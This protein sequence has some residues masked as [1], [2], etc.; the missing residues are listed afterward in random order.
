MTQRTRSTSPTSAPSRRI[1]VV[2]A[3]MAGIAC[4]RT[5][6]QAGHQVRVFE[7]LAAPGG[8]MAS[9]ASPFGS[10]DHGAQYFTVRDA[11]FQQ[12]LTATAPQLCRPWSANTVRVL[13]PFGRVAAAALPPAEAHWVPVPGMDAL[14]RRWAAPLVAAQA[15]EYETQAV[16]ITADTIHPAKW[17]IATVGTAGEPD[18]QHVFGGFDA[19]VLAVPHAQA[20]QLLRASNLAPAVQKRL[21]SVRVGPCWALLL[22]F[23]Q[24]VQ[25]TLAHLGPQWNAARST[26]H[27]IA[28]LARESSKPGRGAVE[29][30]TVQASTAWSAEHQQD[31]AARVQAKLRRAFSEVTGILAE[32]AFAR[33]HG[34]HQAQT[35]AP[36]GQ[37]HVWDARLRIGLAGDWCLGHRVDDA[38]VSGVELALAMACAPRRAAPSKLAPQCVARRLVSPPRPAVSPPLPPVRCTPARWS[39][40]S[41]AG[42]THGPVADAGWCASRTST[43]RAVPLAPTR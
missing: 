36:L 10:F 43:R 28:W 42:S 9:L 25:P 11:R 31:D 39:R 40:R 30:W 34:W 26:H 12:A 21:E 6:V 13:D 33:V 18:A 3:G 22:A 1:A 19:V 37:S 35:L 29:R 7:R 14:V 2:G 41:R 27:R 5:L 4:A 20:Q 24:A 16:A 17:Q 8:R 38:C 23:P 32:P 15:V